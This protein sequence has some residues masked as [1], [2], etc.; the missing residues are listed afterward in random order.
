MRLV[1]RD[2]PLGVARKITGFYTA[3]NEGN[4]DCNLQRTG[5]LLGPS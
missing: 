1:H 5:G 2:E 4:D 3:N